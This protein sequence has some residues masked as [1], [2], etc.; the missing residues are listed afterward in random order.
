VAGE[1]LATRKTKV[2][3]IITKFLY[4][5]D[6]YGY[7][8]VFWGLL[9]EN[10]GIPFPGETILLIAS[11]LAYRGELE[12]TRVIL[13]AILAAFFGDT[14]GYLLGRRFGRRLLEREKKIFFFSRRRIAQAERYFARYG[15]WTV[16]F[17]RFITGARIFGGPLAGVLNMPPGPFLVFD[18]AGAVVWATCISLLGY[19]FGSQWERLMQLL[20]NINLS[21]LLLALIVLAILYWRTRT[22]QPAT[23]AYERRE[24]SH[25]GIDTDAER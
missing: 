6:Q 9:I 22:R 15:T 18:F 21:L 13:F 17:A 2:P 10:A 23:T 16:F 8:A 7:W 11:F 20:R 25:P 14:T 4:F 3:P 1:E 19:F 12:L 5:F 24:K